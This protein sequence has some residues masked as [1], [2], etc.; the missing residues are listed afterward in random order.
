[1]KRYEFYVIDITPQVYN[2]VYDKHC[3]IL[4]RAHHLLV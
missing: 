2:Q 4:Q 3:D 1:M